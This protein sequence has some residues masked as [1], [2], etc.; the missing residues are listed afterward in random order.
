MLLEGQRMG[1]PKVSVI[2]PVYNCEN[3]IARC[4]Q[5]LL[6]QTLH[7][8][9]IIAIDDGSTDKSGAILDRYAEEDQRLRVFHQENGGVAAARNKGLQYAQGTYIGFVDG[10]DYVE[11]DMYQE[12]YQVIIASEPAELCMCDY[13]L[14]YLNTTLTSGPRLPNRVVN[15]LRTEEKED[16]YLRYLAQRPVLWNKLY[17][18][19]A[20]NKVG[21]SFLLNSGEDYLFNIQL[22][23]QIKRATLLSHTFYHYVQR[24]SSIMHDDI[25][26]NND[27]TVQILEHYRDQ[28][29]ENLHMQILI[30]AHLLTGFLFSSHAIGKQISFFLDQIQI[31]RQSPIFLP[32]CKAMSDGDLM[33]LFQTGSM[34]RKFYEI[35][36]FIARACL[37]EKDKLAAREM[38]LI[39]WLRAK[40]KRKGQLNFFE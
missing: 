31:L 10:D 23:Q 9:E 35:L 36:R 25:C 7:E 37:F 40:D 21:L 3:Y 5:S 15:L 38:Q 18:R 20:I 19:E 11:P 28:S 27:I 6:A 34:S 12:M 14:V 29:K 4:I 17:F 26:R 24:K 2:V 32:F 39:G 16:F 8:I 1:A 22:L 30:F 13:D 33:I